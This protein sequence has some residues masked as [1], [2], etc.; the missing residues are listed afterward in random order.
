VIAST[1]LGFAFL[2]RKRV[3]QL[4]GLL[5]RNQKATRRDIAA[6]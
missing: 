3:S 2:V 1:F 6:N 4:F 5:G